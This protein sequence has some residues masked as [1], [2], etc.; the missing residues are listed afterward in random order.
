MTPIKEGE[1][2]DKYKLLEARG[3]GNFGTVFRVKN[4]ALDAERAVKFIELEDERKVGRS[5]EEARNL[6]KCGSKHIVEVYNAD[7]FSIDGKPY[8][9]IEM[10]Y[11]SEGSLR[12]RVLKGG[13]SVKDA[14]TAT[15][16]VLYALDAAHRAGIIHRDVKP[17]N[18]LIDGPNYKLTDFGI[19][20]VKSASHLY[21]N[22]NYRKNA[23]PE[24]QKG[25]MADERSDIYSVGM[26]LFRLLS[27]DGNLQVP[28]D[29]FIDW[30]NKGCSIGLPEFLGFPKYI[31]RRLKAAIRRATDANPNVRYASAQE[32]LTAIEG[33]RVNLPWARDAA[34]GG[35][36][37]K[38]DKE[39][40]AYVEQAKAR[41][42]LEYKI[43]GRRPNGSIREFSTA[44]Q[45]N[46]ALHK[47]IA[48]T[49]LA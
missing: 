35:W 45:A 46:A 39:H 47:L 28:V 9:I 4:L 23:A 19:S 37:A 17:A 1:V 18:I 25:A 32:M 33:L 8:V 41:Y 15:S 43:N 10:E 20:F 11:L 34:N 16:H 31:P 36:I 40:R 5:L 24:C 49:M 6:Y 22:I 48:D 44:A 21:E 14:L 2:I 42:R 30:R 29:Q 26:T 38:S 7:I 13:I 3:S 12:D 27:L